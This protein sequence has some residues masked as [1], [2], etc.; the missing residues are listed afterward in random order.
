MIPAVLNIPVPLTHQLLFL[1]RQELC[2]GNTQFPC[3]TTQ[4]RLQLF[5]TGG[6]GNFTLSLF[7]F[8]DNFPLRSSFYDSIRVSVMWGLCQ[9]LHCNLNNMN[10]GWYDR[11]RSFWDRTVNANSQNIFNTQSQTNVSDIHGLGSPSLSIKTGSCNRDSV[12]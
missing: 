4:A 5:T 3:V 8:P 10:F 11:Y 2:F 9:K 1:I 7:S 12:Y 6:F